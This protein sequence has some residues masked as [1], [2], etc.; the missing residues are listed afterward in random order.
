MKKNSK[1][2]TDKVK[3]VV[4]QPVTVEEKIVVIEKR[5]NNFLPLLVVIASFI[6]SFISSLAIFMY[7]FSNLRQNSYNRPSSF[8]LITNKSSSRDSFTSQELLY[9]DPYSLLNIIDKND[10]KYLLVDIRSEKEYEKEHVKTAINLPLYEGLRNDLSIQKKP[11]VL[12]ELKKISQGKTIIVYGA[13]A[14]T[15]TT[16]QA[17]NYLTDNQLQVKILTVGWNEW[18]FNTNLWLAEEDWGGFNINQYLEIS[19]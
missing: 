9:L 12:A 8:N 17:A 7:I 2:K 18:R 10:K 13:N 15:N 19:N 16:R 4:N 14:Y 6:F 1:D 5:K 11:K 3:E